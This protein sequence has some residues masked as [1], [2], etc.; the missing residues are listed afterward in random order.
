MKC[1]LL[2]QKE[3]CMPHLINATPH[4]IV[5]LNGLKERILVL[6]PSG[7]LPRCAVKVEKQPS[8]M[9]SL[10]QL[11]DV[12]EISISQSTLGDVVGLP[13]KQDNTYFIVS[14]VVA[15]KAKEYGRD[16]L[17]VPDAIRNEK[18]DI[19]GCK[20]FVKP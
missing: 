8:L 5:L 7:I 11:D 1:I 4:Q 10:E 14:L 12:V 16:D 3:V 13:E 15:Q 19:I 6:E 2:E 9:I 17:L 18:G 20:G